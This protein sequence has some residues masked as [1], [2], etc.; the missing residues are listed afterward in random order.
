MPSVSGNLMSSRMRSGGAT[1][2][3]CVAQLFVFFGALLLPLVFQGVLYV[4]HSYHTGYLLLAAG[5]AVCT[6][7]M[8]RAALNRRG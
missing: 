2:F 8:A 5:G 6:F 7:F 1:E 4:T 3:T